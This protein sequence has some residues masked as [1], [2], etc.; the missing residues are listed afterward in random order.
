MQ[1]NFPTSKY[2]LCSL[3][4][5]VARK[6]VAY[7]NRELAP[8]NLTAQQVMALGVLWREENI[9]LGVFAD[10][11]GIGKAAAVS[12]VKRLEAMGLV[13]REAH[14]RDGRLNMLK[15]T[16]QARAMAPLVGEKVAALERAVES[17]VGVENLTVLVK[18]LA[19]IRNLRL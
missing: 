5:Q 2:F 15:L 6:M 9:S 4:T 12:M 16:E 17:A 3:T 8:L 14:P 19:V 7:Y 18:G 1:T 13:Q 11:A 10:R